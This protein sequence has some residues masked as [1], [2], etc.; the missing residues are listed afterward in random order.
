MAIVSVGYDGTVDETQWANLIGKAGSSEYGVDLAGDFAVT[1]VAGAE[2]TIRIAPGKAWGHGVLDVMDV[3]Q[4]I[5]LDA[6]LSGDRY[7]MLVLRR[8]WQPP[9]GAT[10]LVVIKG[11]ASSVNIPGRNTGNLGVLDDQP[12]ALIR[13]AAGSTTVSVHGDLRVW[14]RNGGTTA[15][16][17][18]ALQYLGALGSVVEINGVQWIYRVGSSG[19][20][21]ADL[22][23]IDDTGWVHTNGGTQFIQPWWGRSGDYIRWRRVGNRTQVQI[24]FTRNQGTET[25]PSNGNI[26][27]THIATLPFAARPTGYYVILHGGAAT[28]LTA[29]YLEIDGRVMFTATT[30][31]ET[32]EP[33]RT[34]DL[35]GFFFND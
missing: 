23:K 11:S 26:G 12:I 25:T 31:N 16:D 15:K 34:Y 4:T 33:G 2:R 35:A 8:D 32:I 28:S 19:A 1:P 29:G 3:E 6:S 20:E 27:N 21:W 5:Q 17:T 14:G 24:R 22:A 7:D 18:R 13:V 30:P 10:T 9:G